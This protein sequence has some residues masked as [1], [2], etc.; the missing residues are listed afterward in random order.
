MREEDQN[1]LGVCVCVWVGAHIYMHTHTHKHTLYIYCSVSLFLNYLLSH[2]L[3]LF[4]AILYLVCW[5]GDILKNECPK[6]QFSKNLNN[7]FHPT[8]IY[9]N[10]ALNF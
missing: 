4:P 7:I 2:K 8:R 6:T 10:L 1:K 5:L 3:S 9:N